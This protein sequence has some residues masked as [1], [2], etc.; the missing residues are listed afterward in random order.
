[1]S[2]KA[3]NWTVDTVRSRCDIEPIDGGCWLWAQGVHAASGQPQACI[4]GRPQI[5]GRWLLRHLGRP[6]PDRQPLTQTCG[7]RR[8][9]NPMH[10]APKTHS[11]V[12]R[13]AYATGQRSRAA[14]YAGKLRAA[15]GAGLAK[16]TPAT[17][18][19]IRQRIAAGE[20]VQDVAQ[21]MGLNAETVRRVKLGRTWRTLVPTASVFS[22][23]AGL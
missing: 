9:L 19:S 21:D 16:L 8:C 6:V 5:V 2:G 15:Q 23:G 14:E 12:L 22:L 4:H 13:D 20:T 11:D 3:R 18:G 1:M 10:L 7:N 17:A